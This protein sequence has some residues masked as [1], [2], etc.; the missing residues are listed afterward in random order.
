M[1]AESLIPIFALFLLACGTIY[2][3]L[4]FIKV[5]VPKG[6]FASI[7][8]LRGVLAFSVSIH[9]SMVWFYFLKTGGQ[10]GLP[11]S[12]YT[13]LG[14]SSVAFFFMI[15]A[16][17]FY[18]KLL[19]ARTRSMD[20]TRLYVS[21]I[22]RIMPL[23]IFAI[24]VLFLVAGFES[25]F[26]LREYPLRLLSEF[27]QWLLFMQPDINNIA[28]AHIIIA[29][30]VWSL[31]FEWLFYC[32]LAWIGKIVFKIRTP[33]K[34]LIATGLGF[35]IFL[36]IILYSYSH[37]LARICP[38]AG[39]IAAAFLIRNSHIQRYCSGVW[40][41]ALLLV[42]I[43]LILFF[44]PDVSTPIPFIG[45][46]LVFLIIAGGNDIFGLLTNRLLRYLGMISYSLYLLHGTLLFSCFRFVIGAKKA[47][48][49]S[50]LE[51]WLVIG[52]C[53]ILLILLCTLTYFYIEKPALRKKANFQRF[54]SE[55]VPNQATL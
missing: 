10:W 41:S 12:V 13:H 24:L 34:V 35:I 14:P 20:W 17:L 32:S 25:H 46:C 52:V 8:G 5:D 15:T 36:V 50:P 31:A 2:L 3:L 43:P 23:Y 39:G 11:Y 1:T 30:V 33:I 21:R 26:T 6:R 48:G 16:F 47:I 9:H 28:S 38:F 29:G 19:D 22:Y 45:I 4:R 54:P 37:I 55:V 18:S 49:F 40:A 53:T 51:H 7:D 27:F 42:L 44:Y